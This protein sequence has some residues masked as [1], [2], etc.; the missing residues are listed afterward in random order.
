MADPGRQ[1]QVGAARRPLLVGLLA[2]AALTVAA[3]SRADEV[4]VSGCPQPGVEAG[5]LVLTGADG[6][7]YDVTAAE[8]KPQPGVA[9]TV[10][11]T[12]SQRASLCMQG[13]VLAPARW[14]PT[15]GVGCRA[16]TP[17]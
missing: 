1:L 12:V 15:P 7:L 10:T 6:K 2:L 9:G 14:S 13:I 16:P 17:Q 3:T 4:T 5:C 8:P 11:G